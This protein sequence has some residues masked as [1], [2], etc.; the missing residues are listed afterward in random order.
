MGEMGIS[1]K[2]ELHIS[3]ETIFKKMKKNEK[4]GKKWKKMDPFFFILNETRLYFQLFP[5]PK[6]NE[7]K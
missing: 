6:K 5:P 7:K 4:N 2:M 1:A 3:N